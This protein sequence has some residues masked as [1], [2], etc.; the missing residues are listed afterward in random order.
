[1]DYDDETVRAYFPVRFAVYEYK[2]GEFCG[3]LGFMF[4]EDSMFQLQVYGEW[5][6][7]LDYD[8]EDPDDDVDYPIY[9]RTFGTLSSQLYV[10]GWIDSAGQESADAPTEEPDM[11]DDEQV[12]SGRVSADTLYVTLDPRPMDI[13]D[14]LS[15]IEL[16][17]DTLSD[18]DDVDFP[19][20][21]LYLVGETPSSE[22]Q[23][24][25]YCGYCQE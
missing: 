25:T 9:S 8:S 6:H 4:D 20:F 12:Y 7:L 16:K 11:P 3:K 17:S 13:W 14:I 15:Y 22:D 1:L 5:V 19:A 2:S 10:E 18:E 24:Q 23:Q 21:N